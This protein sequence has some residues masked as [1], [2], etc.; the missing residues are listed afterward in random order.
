MENDNGLTALAIL[1]TLVMEYPGLVDGETQVNGADLVDSVSQ[2]L[3]DC[4][5][6]AQA[7]K[8]GG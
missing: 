8:Q 3:D 1:R 5:E 4:P 2:S 6:L 7:L